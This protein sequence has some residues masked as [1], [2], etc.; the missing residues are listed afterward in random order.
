MLVGQVL[1]MCHV[2]QQLESHNAFSR[3]PQKLHI[4]HTLAALY[5]VMH[6]EDRKI[7]FKQFNL[8]EDA[9]HLS[10]WSVLKIKNLP[11]DLERNVQ[12]HIMERYRNLSSNICNRESVCKLV[13]TYNFSNL[14]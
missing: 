8:I 1:S 2:Y 14:I 11:K 12:G 7:I 3:S 13:S 10:L 4:S 6:Q 5:E 9:R